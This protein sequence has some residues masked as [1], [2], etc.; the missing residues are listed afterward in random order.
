MYVPSFNF[1]T[2]WQAVTKLNVN[3]MAL[4]VT[5]TMYHLIYY[6]QQ[7]Q[8]GGRTENLGGWS[9]IR[10]HLFIDMSW[11]RAMFR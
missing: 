4:K 1:W 8:H 5:V 2:M 6:D 10:W 3:A 7:K 9:G 11:N